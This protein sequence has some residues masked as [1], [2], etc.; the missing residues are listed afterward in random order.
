[1]IFRSV[2][3]WSVYPLPFRNLA[4]SSLSRRKGDRQD[5]QEVGPLQLLQFLRAPSGPLQWRPLSSGGCFSS[6][7]NIMPFTCFPV[8][9][10]HRNT[11]DRRLKILFLSISPL[12]PSGA[13]VIHEPSLFLL[14]LSG[15]F[16]LATGVAQPSASVHPS[17]VVRGRPLLRVLCVPLQGM[18]DNTGCW[19]Q[20]VWQSQPHFLGLI[21]LSI[22]TC[23]D[24]HWWS[25]PAI[26]CHGGKDV[27][28]ELV[29]LCCQRLL[30]VYIG[31]KLGR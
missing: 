12:T 4:W 31:D 28:R 15:D 16:K 21:W 27:S 26:P 19:F 6:H 7:T 9:I 13:E 8:I 10:T 2:N 23:A 22:G 20:R 30:E 18:T 29:D 1:M 17:K 25:C 3:M 5:R 11:L 24:H 14:F